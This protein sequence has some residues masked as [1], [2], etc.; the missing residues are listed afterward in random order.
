VELYYNRIHYGEQ[1]RIV[2]TRK[3]MFVILW[4][5]LYKKIVEWHL[6]KKNWQYNEKN[7][8]FCLLNKKQTKKNWQKEIVCSQW[9]I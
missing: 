3:T 7:I 4:S 9:C 1:L 6:N 8:S 5:L 2:N